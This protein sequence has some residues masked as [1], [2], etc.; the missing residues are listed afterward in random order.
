MILMSSSLRRFGSVAPRRACPARQGTGPARP[1]LPKPTAPDHQR[2]PPNTTFCAVTQEETQ[3]GTTAT[4]MDTLPRGGRVSRAPLPLASVLPDRTGQRR[5]LRLR[6]PIKRNLCQAPTPCYP[7]V[8][9]NCPTMS[10]MS[11][12]TEWSYIGQRTDNGHK[13]TYFGC[14][15][16]R[17][18]TPSRPT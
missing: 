7:L 17:S 15:R 12:M 3:R 11:D 8:S 4:S 18:Q 16:N 1:G 13:R 14:P 6:L 10:N 5:S 9:T 2:R